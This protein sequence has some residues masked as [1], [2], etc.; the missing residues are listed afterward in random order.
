MSNVQCKWCGTKAPSVSALTAN[1]CQRHPSKGRHELYEGSEK[2][3]YI[4]KHCG[5][6]APSIN[7]LTA[8]TCQRHP[9][10]GKHEVAL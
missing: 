7:A 9:S 8:N 5:T 6:S 2:T 1:T 4:C 10:K 3:K